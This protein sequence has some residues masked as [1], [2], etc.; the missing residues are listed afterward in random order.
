MVRRPAA[1]GG[2]HERVDDRR[3][4]RF[5]RAHFLRPRRG[6]CA[7]SR[8]GRAGSARR[9][10]CR[11]LGRRP[12]ACEVAEAPDGGAAHRRLAF[13]LLEMAGGMSDRQFERLEVILGR[14]LM[15][16]VLVASACLAAGLV[17]WMTGDYPSAAD[18]VLAAGLVVLMATPILRVVVSLVEY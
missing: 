15:A 6:E 7:G 1:R 2:G 14:V 11:L 17:L 3:D 16:G 10:A 12:R 5:L 9:I 18:R 4:R 13:V 8:G